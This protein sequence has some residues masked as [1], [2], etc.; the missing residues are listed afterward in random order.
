MEFVG[1]DRFGELTGWCGWCC[2]FPIQAPHDSSQKNPVVAD[3]EKPTKRSAKDR[4]FPPQS[5]QK[6]VLLGLGT[7]GWED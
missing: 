6:E 3:H 2:E 7:D 5:S 4:V 1:V